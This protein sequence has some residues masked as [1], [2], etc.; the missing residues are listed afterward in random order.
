MRTYLQIAQSIDWT[1]PTAKISKYFTVKEAIYLKEWNRLATQDDGLN[2]IVK[3]KLV[4]FFRTKADPVRAIINR[5]VFSKSCFRP[6]K[7]NNLIGGAPLSCHR[8]IEQTVNGVKKICAALDFYCDI[9]GDGDKDGEDC[10]A[11]KDL[12]RPHLSRLGLRME[13]NGK[14][15]RWVHIDD[16]DVGPGSDREFLPK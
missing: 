12:L 13:K 7:Y 10:D 5:A 3:T 16:K 4:Q 9:D 2:L 15:A 11:I 14:G 1:N 8:V 6:E